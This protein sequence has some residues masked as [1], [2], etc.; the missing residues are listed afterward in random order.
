MSKALQ[1]EPLL[2]I[3]FNFY[4][5]WNTEN[6]AVYKRNLNSRQKGILCVPLY[7]LYKM[8]ILILTNLKH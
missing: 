6:I 1:K 2:T 7:V 8:R 4:M 3:V 5:Y